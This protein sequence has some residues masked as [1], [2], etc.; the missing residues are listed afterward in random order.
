MRSFKGTVLAGEATLVSA[1]VRAHETAFSRSWSTLLARVFAVLG[2]QLGDRADRCGPPIPARE[3]GFV[4]LARDPFPPGRLK[5]RG[6]HAN[7]QSFK[8]V[9]FPRPSP[10]TT[11]VTVMCDGWDR[12]RTKRWMHDFASIELE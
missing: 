3:D 2:K 1:P 12:Y 4:P 6:P 5:V 7:F 9:P 10:A 8:I 11:V